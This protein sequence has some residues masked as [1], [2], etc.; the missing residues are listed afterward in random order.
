MNE[1]A[2]TEKAK[3]WLKDQ[4]DL[5]YLKVHGGPRQRAGVPDL[6]LCVRGVFAAVE[7]KNPEG[8]PSEQVPSPAQMHQLR[9]IANAGGRCRTATSLEEVQGLVWAIRAEFG[10]F[11]EPEPVN[12]RGRKTE[13][14]ALKPRRRR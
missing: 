11:P 6:L 2:L 7:L 12:T 8:S 5:W 13:Q 10:V 4:P 14:L 3:K 9:L 1:H